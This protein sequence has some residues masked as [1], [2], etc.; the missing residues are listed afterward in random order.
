MHSSVMRTF[1]CSGRLGW[2]GWVSAQGVVCLGGVCLGG[3]CLGGCLWE[4]GVC[5]GGVYLGGLCLGCVRPPLTESQTDVK[6]LP[7][8]NYYCGW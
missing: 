5:Q 6:T 2:G 7:F 4:G 8:C 1:R 3:V